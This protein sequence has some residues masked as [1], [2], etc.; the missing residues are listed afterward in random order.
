M[1]KNAII[2]IDN[3]LWQFCDALYEELK[4]VNRRFPTV[5]AWTHWDLWQG[6]CS[7]ED[8]FRT[9]DTIHFNQDSDR[10]RPY[11]EARGFLSA[12]REHGYHITIASH[13]SGDFREQTERWLEKHGLVY[14][15]LH[16][17]HHKTR[18]FTM[19]IDVVVDDFPLVL[20][21]AVETGALGVGLLFPWNREYANNEIMLFK[22]LHEVLAYI[23]KNQA[24]R[25]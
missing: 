7:E 23:L 13:R 17:S 9:I 20:E 12:L 11:P 21:R 16:L 18:L 14:D 4:K 8:F 25:I 5:D 19:P 1:S 10:Y 15:V 2:D 6:Y 24:R 3:T 22:D